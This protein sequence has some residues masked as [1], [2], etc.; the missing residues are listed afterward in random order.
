MNGGYCMIDVTGLNAV[1]SEAQEL[2]GLYA[3]IY[4]CMNL[5]KPI[6]FVNLLSGENGLATP[7]EAVC[8]LGENR[9]TAKTQLA[10]FVITNADS[11]TIQA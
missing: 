6:M 2:V 5:N 4:T 3:K 10:T 9:I 8:I 7:L 1:S 11:V